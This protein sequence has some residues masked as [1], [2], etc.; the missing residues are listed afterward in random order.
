MQHSGNIGSRSLA[1][2]SAVGRAASILEGLEQGWGTSDCGILSHKQDSFV[3]PEPQGFR[4]CLG[5]GA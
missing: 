3:T 5:R 2:V 1:C 4:V